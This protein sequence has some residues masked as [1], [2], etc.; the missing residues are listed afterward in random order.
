MMSLGFND[1]LIQVRQMCWTGWDLLRGL[2]V[3]PTPWLC[4]VHKFVLTELGPICDSVNHHNGNRNAWNHPISEKVEKWESRVTKYSSH[5]N[6]YGSF[7]V[8]F[9]TV[10]LNFLHWKA[11]KNEMGGVLDSVLACAPFSNHQANEQTALKSL[12]QPKPEAGVQVTANQSQ[13]H[14]KPK[15]WM[16]VCFWPQQL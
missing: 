12:Q 7:I 6:P 3:F 15:P 8:W 10:K 14:S 1:K 4:V 13:S 9:P 16:A 5:C 11:D 2:L